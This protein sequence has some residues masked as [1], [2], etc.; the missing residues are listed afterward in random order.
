MTREKAMRQTVRANKAECTG[1]GAC[2]SICPKGA[3]A[4]KPDAEGFLYPVVDGTLCIS[5]D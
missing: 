5:C 3:I 4:M 2:V 1:C